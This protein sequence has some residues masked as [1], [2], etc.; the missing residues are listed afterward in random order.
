MVLNICVLVFSIKNINKAT[1]GKAE[2][3]VARYVNAKHAKPKH[4]TTHNLLVTDT[5]FIC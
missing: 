5:L 1:R 3:T 2:G 4:T